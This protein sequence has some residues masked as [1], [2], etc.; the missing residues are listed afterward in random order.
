[1][2]L[3]ITITVP[4]SPEQVYD[5]VVDVRSWWTGEISGPTA[6]LGQ[7]FTY[8]YEDKH[9]STH[10]VEELRRGH[11]VVWLTTDADLPFAD[12]PTEWIGTRQVFDIT[13]TADGTELRFT[14][15]GL[16]PDL[17][18]YHSC[19]NAWSYFIRTSLRE[20][21]ATAPA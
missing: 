6:E 18:C 15:D 5:A 20:R 9:R 3:T 13:P 21:I 7:D 17:D 19:S 16:L 1:M 2:S 14:H 11:R 4:Q 8:R 12:D 10:R